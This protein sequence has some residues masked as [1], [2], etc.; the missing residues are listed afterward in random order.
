MLGRSLVGGLRQARR[1]SCPLAVER[2]GRSRTSCLLRRLASSC[3]RTLL[4]EFLGW[5]RS[6]RVQGQSRCSRP[7]HA[8]PTG[9]PWIAPGP[10]AAP[11]WYR[12]PPFPH[13]IA[14]RAPA[15]AFTRQRSPFPKAR[16]ARDEF[17][18]L[19]TRSAAPRRSDA[20]HEPQPRQGRSNWTRRIAPRSDADRP[21]PGQ[22][23]TSCIAG[24]A[25]SA[26]GAHRSPSR[27]VARGALD[28][29][30]PRLR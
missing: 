19:V 28:W 2:R 27:L 23:E 12:T 8:V 25:G 14:P 4:P 18:V 7:P 15:G 20:V 6:D 21:P 26:E 29:K 17:H 24:P 1:R 16:P 5:R 22:E 13:P 30:R 11:R 10:A 3:P 9:T